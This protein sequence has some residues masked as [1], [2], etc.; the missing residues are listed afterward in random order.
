MQRYIITL[1][2]DRGKIKICSV[3][4]SI[5]SATE[6]VLDYEKAPESAI[7]NIKILPFKTKKT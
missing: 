1:K 7:I 6:T 5:K 3:S 4:N 2:H